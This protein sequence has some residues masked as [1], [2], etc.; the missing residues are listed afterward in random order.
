MDCLDARF[1]VRHVN[2][3]AAEPQP[4]SS[5]VG[6]YLDHMAVT[7]SFYNASETATLLRTVRT[8]FTEPLYVGLWVHGHQ[9]VAVCVT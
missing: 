7:L 6:V 5:R 2:I 3:T 8:T 1:M 9:A 4:V